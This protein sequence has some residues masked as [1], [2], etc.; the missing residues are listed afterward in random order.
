MFATGG[1][2]LE[3]E[4]RMFATHNTKVGHWTELRTEETEEKT[5]EINEK[6]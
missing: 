2:T 5:C 1:R 4:E 3:I 6:M